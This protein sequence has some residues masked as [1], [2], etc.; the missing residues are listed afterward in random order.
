[1]N[2]LLV[3]GVGTVILIAAYFTY[4]KFLAT[5]VFNL[6]DANKTPAVEMEDGVEL[7]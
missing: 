7:C 1:M 2:I 6:D 5:K 4:G 3:V